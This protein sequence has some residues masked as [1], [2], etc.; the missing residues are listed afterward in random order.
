MAHSTFL[1][2][3]AGPKA[4]ALGTAAPSAPSSTDSAPAS[5]A[6]GQAPLSSW[7]LPAMMM[8]MVGF[9]LFTS[10]NQRKREAETR[11]RLKKGEK[12]VSQSGLIG[13]LVDMDDKIARVKIAPGTNVQML[14]STVS[15]YE[16]GAASVSAGGTSTAAASTDKTLKDLKDAKATAEKKG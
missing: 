12:V 5:G 15:P 4:G 16:P 13:E 2:Q 9:M 10:R 6:Q 3:P 14:V 1:L 11:A 8:V 7:I